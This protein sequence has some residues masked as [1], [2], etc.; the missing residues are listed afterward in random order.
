LPGFFNARVQND[1]IFLYGK[2]WPKSALKSAIAWAAL[3]TFTVPMPM[4]RAGF[5]LMPKSSKK[6]HAS[7]AKPSRE[8]ASS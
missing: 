2:S 1:A 5:K 7:G 4:A 8:Q 6:I 3:I